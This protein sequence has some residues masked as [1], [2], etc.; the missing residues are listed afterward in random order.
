MA[1]INRGKWHIASMAVFASL[2]I[3]LCGVQVEAATATPPLVEQVQAHYAQVTN[4]ASMMYAEEVKGDRV[5]RRFGRAFFARPSLMRNELIDGTE[6][7]DAGAEAI[8]D[9]GEKMRGHQGGM[10]RLLTVS[11]R[12]DGLALKSLLGFTF[13]E[14]TLG[15]VLE[16]LNLYQQLG[17]VAV[18]GAQRIGGV[19]TVALR[20][21]L[22]AGMTLPPEDRVAKLGVSHEMVYVDPRS[23]L[24]VAWALYKDGQRVRLLAFEVLKVNVELDPAI[25]R[26]VKLQDADRAALLRLLPAAGWRP[27][28][29]P[30]P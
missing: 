9:G 22:A 23:Y 13:R 19:E 1:S 15:A 30:A 26:T 27:E 11:M 20:L 2:F 10:L 7:G 6:F 25:F 3:T 17:T 29:W 28:Q 24:P 5:Q 8:Y 16:R 18:A 4:Y 21:Q 14:M 12:Y